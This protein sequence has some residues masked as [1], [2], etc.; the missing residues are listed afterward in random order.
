M[1]TTHLCEQK[2]FELLTTWLS[3]YLSVIDSGNTGV[4]LPFSFIFNGKKS[5]TFLPNIPVNIKVMD[6]ENKKHI[7]F[8]FPI[9][10]ST[11][12]LTCVLVKYTDYPIVEWTLYF[13]NT[14]TS[15]SAIISDVLPINTVFGVKDTNPVP[16]FVLHHHTGSP[17]C[18]DD[19]RPHRMLLM[20]HQNKRITTCGGRPANSDLP[21]FNIEYAGHGVI[22]ALGWAGQWATNFFAANHRNLNISGGQELTK[23]TLLPGEEVRTPMI[24]LQFWQDDRIRAHNVWRR[25]MLEH[26]MPK[27]HGKPLE[28]MTAGCSSWCFEEMVKA[29]TASQK[30]FIDRYLGEGIDI[31]Y[32]WMDAGW[33]PVT[34]SWHETG[35]WEV[36]KARFPNGLREITDYGHNKGVKSIVWFEPERV[37]PGTWLWDTHPEWLLSTDGKWKLLNLGNTEAREW[38]INQADKIINE[39]GIDLYR[40]DFNIEPL[41]FWQVNDAPDRQGITEIKYVEGLYAYLDELRHR[42]PGMLIDICASGGRRNDVETLRRGIPLLRSDY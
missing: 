6:S 13:K 3:D 42:H 22:L 15:D 31:D 29:D 2:D 27:D 8:S 23:F 5:D 21:Y 37:T 20:Y 18:P 39:Q 35:T 41:K 28:P 12:L 4:K 1:V 9:P 25:W 24:V 16:E 19:Y 11:I 32:W 34:K 40:T 7:T 38:W 36:D 14:G 26:N 10:D 33:Y 17:N 30:Y